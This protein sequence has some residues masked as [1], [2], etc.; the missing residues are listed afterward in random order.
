VR[1][2]A[3]AVRMFA[4]PTRIGRTSGTSGPS[5]LRWRTRAEG[6]CRADAD[7]SDVG[8]VGDVGAAMANAGGRMFA[9]P[10]RIGR[11][12]WVRWRAR[13][14]GCS[15]RQGGWGPGDAE[16][17][18]AYALAQ[19]TSSRKK[20]TI[21][22]DRFVDGQRAEDVGARKPERCHRWCDRSFVFDEK[23][24]R[25]VIATAK[26]A[27][28]VDT[29]R[30]N[31]HGR[32]LGMPGLTSLSDAALLQGLHVIVG[33]HRRVTVELILHLG[34][35]DARRLHVEKGFPSLFSYCVELLRFSEDEACRRIEASRLARLFP[36]AYPLLESGA[37]SLTVLG[38]L[39]PHL[40]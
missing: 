1:W 4:A 23:M 25:A 30:E 14:A 8:D 9:A 21:R 33:S 7:R 3:R 6:C 34:E 15:P 22:L 38:L 2:R 13:A 5:R 26:R 40:T 31:H 28:C 17:A 39:K 19:S 10:T 35:V 36:A 24:E 16:D 29:E 27:P 12:S 20:N 37:L 18:V 32:P 11:P